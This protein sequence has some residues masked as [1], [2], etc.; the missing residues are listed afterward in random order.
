MK[1]VLE[2]IDEVRRAGAV[3]SEDGSLYRETPADKHTLIAYSRLAD[4]DVEHVVA[5][6]VSR[7]RA[8][9]GIVEWDVFAHDPQKRLPDVLLAAGFTAEPKERVLSVSVTPEALQLCEA[10]PYDIRRVRDLDGVQDI[11]EISREIGRKNVDD[12][13]RRL[14]TSIRETPSAVSAYVAYV[15]D[16]PVACARL[17]FAPSEQPIAWLCGGRTKSTHRRRGLYTA[18]VRTRIE[19]ALERG[20]VALVVDALPT[21]EPILAKRGFR[22]ISEKQA[23]LLEP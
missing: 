22:A 2:M 19:E 15:D 6:E 18:L 16:K 9:D 3:P 20:C 17:H 7:A 13:S 8:I 4:S 10:P 1:D 5:T 11:A 21:S 14:A 12:E 23:F